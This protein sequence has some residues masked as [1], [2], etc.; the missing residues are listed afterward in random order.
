LATES[1]DEGI[2]LGI[3]DSDSGMANEASEEGRRPFPNGNILVVTSA[4]ESSQY[5]LEYWAA[6]QQSLR[7]SM[8][9]SQQFLKSVGVSLRCV[10]PQCDAG[11][12]GLVNEFA[13]LFG[14]IGTQTDPTKEQNATTSAAAIDIHSA[15]KF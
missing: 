9:L 1:R 4:G 7:I 5:R 10:I 15:S 2:A 3:G 11:N 8:R 12:C 6:A 14:R 13:F